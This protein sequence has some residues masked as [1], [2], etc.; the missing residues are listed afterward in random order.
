MPTL[1]LKL[2]LPLPTRSGMSFN[3]LVLKR[4]ILRERLLGLWAFAA[5]KVVLGKAPTSGGG[6]R[7]A[8]TRSESQGS[9]FGP[10]LVPL[11]LLLHLLVPLASVVGHAWTRSL[12]GALPSFALVCQVLRPVGLLL[13]TSTGD[14]SLQSAALEATS[15]SCALRT[16]ARCFVSSSSTFNLQGNSALCTLNRETDRKKE[17]ERRREQ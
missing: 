2:S 3:P 17:R 11:E 9:D 14:M 8:E 16:L 1:T 6:C 15:R 4:K 7:V 13:H 10:L 5:I 12:S